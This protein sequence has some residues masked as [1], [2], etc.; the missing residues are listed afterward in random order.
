MLGRETTHRMRHG[1]DQSE[2]RDCERGHY[3]PLYSTESLW[4]QKLSQSALQHSRPKKRRLEVWRTTA[5][6]SHC[7][8]QRPVRMRVAE[9]V[10]DA[11]VAVHFDGERQAA[12]L[13]PEREIPR[14][15]HERQ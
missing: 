5:G 12:Q 7:E 15:D 4:C 14:G 1:C 10:D 3:Q 8:E 11:G 6:F 13:P 2:Q 9:G